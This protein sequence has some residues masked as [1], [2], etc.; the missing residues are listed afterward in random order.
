MKRECC[1][2]DRTFC[3]SN[4]RSTHATVLLP[5]AGNEEHT[6]TKFLT[7][8]ISSASLEI[9][10]SKLCPLK[11]EQSN[12]YYS[13]DIVAQ[14]SVHVGYPRPLEKQEVRLGRLV[15]DEGISRV[16]PSSSKDADDLV[17]DYFLAISR[18][19]IVFSRFLAAQGGQGRQ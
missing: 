14:V 17:G 15:V 8:L 13:N 19:F 9:T 12:E 18:Q 3:V 16:Q 5:D 10:Q 2:S 1:R 6:D 7:P 11:D 4:G